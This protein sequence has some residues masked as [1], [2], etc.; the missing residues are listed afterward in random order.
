MVT[1]IFFFLIRQKNLLIKI[2][3]DIINTQRIKCQNTKLT[4]LCFDYR[5]N[6]NK[7]EAIKFLWRLFIFRIQEIKWRLNWGLVCINETNT[8]SSHKLRFVRLTQNRLISI[9]LTYIVATN[10]ELNTPNLK[11]IMTNPNS[12]HIT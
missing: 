8:D 3:K 12:H 1:I 5:K 6:V 9:N 7:K 4:R 11:I 2:E 10:F